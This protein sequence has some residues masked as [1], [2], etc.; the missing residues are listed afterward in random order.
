MVFLE[1]RNLSKR[2][3]LSSGMEVVAG[4]LCG[5]GFWGCAVEA[6][7]E[8]RVGLR[9]CEGRGGKVCVWGKGWKE[10]ELFDLWDLEEV[11][12]R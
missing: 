5:D 9:R 8:A 1:K 10:I 3:V 6:S 11:D 12:V 7:D 4:A 2:L